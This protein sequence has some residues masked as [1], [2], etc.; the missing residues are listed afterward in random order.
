MTNGDLIPSENTVDEAADVERRLAHIRELIAAAEVKEAAK[1]TDGSK[2]TR[3]TTHEENVV[4]EDSVGD[5][6]KKVFL[7]MIINHV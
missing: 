5:V 2:E 7:N 4:H 3:V 1:S 6:S